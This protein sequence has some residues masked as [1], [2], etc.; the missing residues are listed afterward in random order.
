MTD[1]AVLLINLDDS[2]GRLAAAQTA[3]GVQG[4]TFTR[5]PGVDGRQTP[6]RAVE[7]YDAEG[8]QN[9]FGRDLNGGEVGAFQSHLRALAAFLDSGAAYGLI[10]EDDMDPDAK[11]MGFVQGIL[12]WQRGRWRE[13]WYVANLGAKRQKI[14]THLATLELDGATLDVLRGHYFPM[15]ATALLWTRAGAQ[16]FLDQFGGID[17]PWDHATRRWLTETDMGLT[18]S[19]PLFLTTGADS[20]IDPARGAR[21]TDGRSRFYRWRRIKRNWGDRLRAMRHKARHRPDT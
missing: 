16:A 8:A 3:L 15:L 4:V 18:V 10:L 7:A 13:D 14:T 12:T 17:C 20:Q 5:V 21:G 6:P 11:A 9:Y 2:P 19:P 1:L